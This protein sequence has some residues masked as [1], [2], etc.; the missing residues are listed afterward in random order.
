[1]AIQTNELAATVYQHIV[2]NV[3][4]ALARETAFL[5]WLSKDGKK[6]QPGGL[7]IQFPMKLIANDS[8]GFISGTNAITGINPSPQLQY[9][10]LNWKYYNFNVNFTLADFTIARGK[11]EVV[12]YMAGKTDG[13]LEDAM[14]EISTG[15]HGSSSSAPLNPEGLE[16]IVAASGTSYA[17]LTDTDY[18][19]NAYLP[20][21]ATDTTLNYTNVNKM[22]TE[23]QARMRSRKKAKK[24]LGLTNQ[25]V[26]ARYKAIV[27]NQQMFLDNSTILKSG[28]EGFMVNGIEFY[29]DADCPGSQDGSTND[30]HLYIFPVDIMR[31]YYNF[32]FGNKSPFDGETKMPN[33]PIMSIQHYMSFNLVCT[34]RRLVAVNKTFIA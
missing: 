27:Q 2:D 23:L 32:G 1:M 9:G 10:V 4:D 8:S 15:V 25:A 20:Y 3:P 13:G 17:S 34:N 7:Y 19:T 29:L 30:N 14:R 11:E 12:D 22:I 24:M 21:I 28:F 33:Q 16:D 5:D 26:Y 6:S 18:A 31:L